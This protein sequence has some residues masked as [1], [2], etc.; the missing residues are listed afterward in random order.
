MDNRGGWREAFALDRAQARRAFERAAQ[1]YDE[2]AALQRAIGEQLLQRLDL[3]RLVP[4]VIL[5]AGCGTGHG[6]R[7]LSHRYRG[8]RV[9]GVDIA[10]NMLRR[11][12]A[13]TPWW[14][15]LTG[16]RPLLACGDIERL[17]L[18]TAAVDLIVSNLALQWCDPQAVYAEFLRVLRPGGLLMFTSFGPDT[19]QELRAAWRAVDAAAHVHA[20]PDM[21]DLGDLLLRTG[22]ADPV[23]DVERHTVMYRDVMQVLR[24]LKRIGAHNV[25][26]GR[27]RGLTGKGR[28]ARFRTAYEAMARNGRIPATFEVVY[29]HAWAPTTAARARPEAGGVAVVS[30]ERL[31]RSRP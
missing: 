26:V 21:H 28:F 19:L 12:Y 23:M 14:V 11:A 8:A 29:G 3:V 13:R 24:E 15:R 1:S 10:E 5:D 20:F 22:F 25:A 27:P 18:A 2:A 16:L 17:P 9:I 30:L 31:R 6:V 7:H 4:A